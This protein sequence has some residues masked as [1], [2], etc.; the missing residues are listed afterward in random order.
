MN[1]LS[2]FDGMSC[3]RI[4]LERAGIHVDNYFA[5]EIDK[6]A[7]KVSN[8]NYPDIL[9]IGSVENY[10]S[11]D[12]DWESIDLVLAGSPCQ[13]FSY[14]GEQLAF[15][16]GRSKLYFTFE[17]VL[18]K[19]K[20]AKFLLENVRMKPVHLD[21]ISTRLGVEPIKINSNTVSAQNRVRYYWCDWFV[22]S[23][24]SDG[25]TLQ[26]VIE[27]AVG[28]W[29][30]PRGWNKGGFK[31]CNKCPT[32]TT[33]SWQYNFLWFDKHNNKFKFTPEQAERFQTVPLGYTAVVS[34]N[35]RFKL[36]GN[37]WTVDVIAHILGGLRNDRELHPKS[38]LCD[39]QKSRRRSE[40]LH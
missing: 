22:D 40:S 9:H 23:L 35:Q 18:K 6:W 12:M 31:D 28:I 16:D 32:L 15:E 13:G 17:E 37:G 4:A 39:Q 34:D 10:E 26:D 2:L 5:S 21:T 3:G 29:T 24:E 7:V 30:W 1:V 25:E 20:N 33:S 8:H 19:C 27:E 36:L 14:A 11:W 38:V